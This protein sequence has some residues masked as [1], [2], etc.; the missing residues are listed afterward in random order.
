M[1]RNMVTSRRIDDKEIQLKRQ[2]R[3]FFQISGAGH[4]AVQ[5]AIAFHMRKGS[6]WLFPYYRDRAICLGLGVTPRDM[7]LQAFGA[8]DD[9]ASRGRQMPSHWGAAALRIFT[10]SSPT[11]TECLPGVG[12]AEAGRYLLREEASGLAGAIAHAAADEVVV[13]TIGEGSTSEG[14]FWEALNSASTLKLPVVF[15]VEDNGYAISVPVEVQTPGGSISK[16][17]RSYPGLFVAETDGC[18][19]L[20][21]YDA[22]RYA[23]AYARERKGPS[24]VHAHVIR[25]Y[26][27]SLSDDERLYR[28]EAERKKDRRARPARVVRGFPRAGGARHGRGPREAARGRGRRGERRRGRRRRC[29]PQPAP[30]TV[31]AHI[32]SPDVDPDF[33]RLRHGGRARVRGRADDDG[34]S[35]Q[36]R[37]PRRDGPRRTH[38]DLGRGRGGR[39]PRRRARR[40]QGQGR[41]LQ[42]DGRP[43]EGVRARARLQLPARRGGHRGARA[44]LG[45]ARTEARRRDPVLRLH[46]A[47]D[48]ADSR[49]ARHDALALG[50]S[51]PRSGRHPGRDRRLSH[52]RRAVPLA[53]GRGDV[54]AHPGPARRDA[55]ERAR[56]ERPPPDR[57]PLRR[58]RALP[59]AQAPVPA[60]AQQGPLSGAGFH[61]PVRQ[62]E[63]PCGPG[64]TS[65]S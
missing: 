40:M 60:D 56:R 20:A 62:G 49:R 13:V 10:T 19:F 24:L 29:A 6:D 15:V 65:R 53:V 36:C 54:H 52:R 22:L 32:Y 51:V 5:T 39:E 44:R 55:V 26:S 9:P 25:P 27:H 8:A 3:I 18:D 31:Q 45:G 23:F 30:E 11:S 64:R 63:A 14:E 38:R 34:R 35:H 1:Y 46:L 16:L 28:S 61:D 42:G 7:F 48:A 4:E 33:G 43:P 41:R 2:N 58:P 17:V 21:S 37:A 59:R 57:D 50:R 47:R 12:A